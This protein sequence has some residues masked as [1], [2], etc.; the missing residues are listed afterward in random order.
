MQEKNKKRYEGWLVSNNFF[1]RAIAVW[2]HQ[3]FIQA[4]I[5]IILFFIVLVWAF[6]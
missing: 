4:I 6:A 1:K 2:I 5:M 3:A